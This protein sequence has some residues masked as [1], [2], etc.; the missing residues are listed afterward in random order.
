VIKF[1]IAGLPRSGTTWLSVFLTTDD[2]VCLHDPFATYTPEE[3]AKWE[4]GICDTALWYYDDWC[5]ANTDKFIIIDRSREDVAKA[6]S[7]KS[8]PTLPE[9]VYD[10]FAQKTSEKRIMFEVLFEEETIQELWE[11]IYPD[12]PFNRD[13]WL[14]FKDIYMSPNVVERQHEKSKTPTEV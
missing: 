7:E 13:R 8:L 11:Y 5:K 6:L 14:Q 2:C 1:I 10:T 3:L 12:K 4:G 9:E